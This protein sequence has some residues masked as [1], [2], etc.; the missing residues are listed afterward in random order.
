METNDNNPLK[1]TI[2]QQDKKCPLVLYPGEILNLDRPV[3]PIRPQNKINITGSLVPNKDYYV[4]EKILEYFTSLSFHINKPCIEIS[5]NKPE[6]NDIEYIYLDKL[7]LEYGF[8]KESKEK[9]IK[10]IASTSRFLKIECNVYIKLPKT[11]PGS[12]LL[13]EYKYIIP[14]RDIPYMLN[15]SLKIYSIA[16]CSEMESDLGILLNNTAAGYYPDFQLLVKDKDKI[17][18]LV[19]E[20]DSIC[21]GI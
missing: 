15:N 10:K 20:L 4:S 12:E 1:L 5:W 16:N 2:W 13:E 14:Y 3:L 7:S 19:E 17:I 9:E 18:Q 8:I 6:L 21:I 11:P